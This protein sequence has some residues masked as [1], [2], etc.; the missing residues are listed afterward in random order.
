MVMD[1]KVFV[2]VFILL[3]SGSLLQGQVLKSERSY[4]K[5]PVKLTKVVLPEKK[6]DTIPPGILIYMP[7]LGSSTN[8][9][10]TL[11]TLTLIG[12]VT[13]EHGIA[14]LLVNSEIIRVTETGLFSTELRLDPGD[15]LS[16]WPLI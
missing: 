16:L 14:S 6:S 7:N 9:L 10:S 4:T 8:Y 12:K 13:D 11:A 3:L 15:K 5:L 1:R 2:L